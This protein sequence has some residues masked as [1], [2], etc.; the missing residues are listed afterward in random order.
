VAAIEANGRQY[1]PSANAAW[2]ERFPGIFTIQNG[3]MHTAE[4]S[5]P[6]LGAVA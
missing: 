3:R 4:I 2:K 6:G 1:V 5:G